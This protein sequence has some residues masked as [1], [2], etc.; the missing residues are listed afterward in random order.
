MI[1]D[2]D[3]M[4][5]VGVS[6]TGDLLDGAFMA[7][8]ATL[9]EAG[10]YIEGGTS[11]PDKFDFVVPHIPSLWEALADRA[12]RLGRGYT[13]DIGSRYRISNNKLELVGFITIYGTN[14]LTAADG[15]RKDVYAILDEDK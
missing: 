4:L 3:V 1:E 9:Q 10:F 2:M 11:A 14:L 6:E 5:P 15:F 13:L 12:L 7:V 8:V